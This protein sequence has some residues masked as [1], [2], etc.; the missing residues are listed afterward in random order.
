MADE[1][2]EILALASD[3]QDGEANDPATRLFLNSMEGLLHQARL[4]VKV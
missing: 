2:D 1:P 4:I 3:L